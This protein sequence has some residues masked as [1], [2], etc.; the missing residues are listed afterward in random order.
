MDRFAREALKFNTRPASMFIFLFSA[1]CVSVF[2][3]SVVVVV[4][5]VVLPVVVV[6]VA[7]VAVVVIVNVKIR[8]LCWLRLSTWEGCCRFGVA[9]GASRLV[10]R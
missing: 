6:V 9:K 3:D 5:V 4:A 1:F 7:V 10:E 2:K 8:C